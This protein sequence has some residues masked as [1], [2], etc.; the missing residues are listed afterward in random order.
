MEFLEAFKNI[1]WLILKLT[2]AVVGL[3][4]TPFFLMGAI[5]AATSY[6]PDFWMK[7][8]ARTM[9]LLTIISPIGGIALSIYLFR[10]L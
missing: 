9:T 4:L 8:I 5:F 6:N 10:C 2:P 1:L 3:S 7:L